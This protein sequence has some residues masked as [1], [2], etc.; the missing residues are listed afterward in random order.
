MSAL[1]QPLLRCGLGWDLH[2]LVEGGPLRLGGIDIPH[3]K[4]AHGHS[5]GDVI[6]HALTDAILGAVGAGDI[7]S[8]FAD[9]DPRWRGADSALFL[10]EALRVAGEQGLAV[11]TADVTVL[12]ERPKVAPYRAAIVGR[13]GELF[14]GVTGRVISIK[15]KTNEGLGAIGG[16]D[17]IAALA[18]VGLVG[19][20]ERRG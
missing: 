14:G 11:G 12:L 15:A 6:L 4:R 10:G 19:C 2:R 1:L 16:G 7:G 5:D 17:A 13:L 20:D 3:D 8:H 18:V 9:D